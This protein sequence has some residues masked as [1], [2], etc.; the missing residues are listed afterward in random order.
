MKQSERSFKAT[1]SALRDG[2]GMLRSNLFSGLLSYLTASGKTL[3]GSLGKI[4][5]VAKKTK[6]TKIGEAITDG[7]SV[8]SSILDEMA[9]GDFTFF[10]DLKNWALNLPYRLVEAGVTFGVEAAQSL[11]GIFT[12]SM[13]LFGSALMSISEI[14]YTGIVNAWDRISPDLIESIKTGI[15]D[16]LKFWGGSKPDEAGIEARRKERGN[17]LSSMLDK[18]NKQVDKTFNSP[19]SFKHTKEAVGD[20]FKGEPLSMRFEKE[21]ALRR[22]KEEYATKLKTYNENRLTLQKNI[23]FANRAKAGS[24]VPQVQSANSD[25]DPFGEAFFK[26][27]FAHMFNKLDAIDIT[28]AVKEQTKQLRMMYTELS[29][30]NTA[31]VGGR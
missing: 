20:I 8:L 21:E 10:K 24:L 26:Q 12:S 23:E 9:R 3:T 18:F 30:M 16:G 29:A 5:E 13:K 27:T 25:A 28:E 14:I 1:M 11:Q 6:W 31:L 15:K 2:I 17:V 22:K 4:S 19:I 7:T